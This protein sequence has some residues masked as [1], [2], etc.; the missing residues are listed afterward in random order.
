M[1][2]TGP[3]SRLIEELDRAGARFLVVWLIAALVALFFV[4]SVIFGSA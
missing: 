4:L 2:E 1:M 3:L